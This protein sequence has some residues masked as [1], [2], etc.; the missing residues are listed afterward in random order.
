MRDQHPPSSAVEALDRLLSQ[1]ADLR[2]SD[3]HLDVDRNGGMQARIRRDGVL[4]PLDT[5]TELDG[6]AMAG[7]AKYLAGLRSYESAL[8]QEGRIP[9]DATPVGRELRVA[10]Y[11]TLDGEKIVFRIF[12]EQA[13]ATL[14]ELELP[15]ETQTVLA[16]AVTQPDGL[17]LLTGPAGSGKT[18]TIYACLKSLAETGQRHILTIE[19]PVER[20]VEGIMQT[21]IRPE[22]GLDFANALRHLLRQDPQVIVLGEIRDDET[23]RMAVRSAFTGHLVIGTLHAGSCRGV[24]ERLL[25]MVE[26]RYAALAC[27]RLVVNQRLVRRLCPVCGGPGCNECLETGFRGRIPI[28]EFAAF[29]DDLRK[30]IRTEGTEGIRPQEPLHAN[31]RRRVREGVTSNDEISRL[32][33]TPKTTR[34]PAP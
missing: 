5:P 16:N 15:P 8:P 25:D 19:D 28:A 23:A 24:V 33:G 21:Q 18:T 26:D 3:L 2:A 10:T 13:V 17:I 9:A 20:R 30:R 34:R 12:A 29:D 14:K 32:L 11:P 1:A 4:Q 7:R 6:I 22:V 31:A 27:L